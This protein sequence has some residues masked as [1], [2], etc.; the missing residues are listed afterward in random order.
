LRRWLV[1]ISSNA[2][3]ELLAHHLTAV[4]DIERAVTQ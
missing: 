3:P 4:G 1:P 2:S